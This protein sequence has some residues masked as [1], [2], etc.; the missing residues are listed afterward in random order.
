MKKKEIKYV[1]IS[2]GIGGKY[3]DV[4]V[5]AEVCTNQFAL[6]IYF[7]LYLWQHVLSLF[8]CPSTHACVSG[9]FGK[10]TQ[11]VYD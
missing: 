7:H 4:C 9:K 6:A 10:K 2:R 1:K 11:E 8:D 5:H 3:V